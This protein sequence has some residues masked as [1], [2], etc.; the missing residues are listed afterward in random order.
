MQR[1]LRG[2]V[3][4]GSIGDWGKNPNKATMESISKISSMLD[5]GLER[6]L[7]DSFNADSDLSARIDVGGS[8]FCWFCEDCQFSSFGQGFTIQ[9]DEESA[10]QP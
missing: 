5:T 2:L 4:E 7:D 6:L 1:Y 9:S 10:G 8:K 3:K